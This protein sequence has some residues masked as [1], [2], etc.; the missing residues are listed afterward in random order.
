MH[1][2]KWLL[3]SPVV[4]SKV[5][6]QDRANKI[7]LQK[8]NLPLVRTLGVMRIATEDVFTIDQ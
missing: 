8:V 3:N 2:H 1:T 6:R 5:L 7:N 4:L